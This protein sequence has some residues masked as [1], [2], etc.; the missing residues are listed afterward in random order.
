MKGLR[1]WHLILLIVLAVGIVGAGIGFLIFGAPKSSEPVP[2]TAFI[3]RV[4][5]GDT[6]VLDTGEYLR[7]IGIDTPEKDDYYF[8][9]AT[10]KN[11]ELVLGKTVRL[12][13]DVSETDRYNR[14]LRYV[15]VGDLFV[16]A[17]LVRLGYAKAWD[18]PPDSKHAQE[19]DQLQN[20]ALTSK[21]GMHNQIALDAWSESTSF[22]VPTPRT[23]TPSYTPYT[24]RNPSIYDLP[25]ATSGGFKLK[26][27]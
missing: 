23:Q 19:L 3:T 22:T 13:K 10:A 7:Y 27:Y 15:Y 18:Y 5:D 6:I 20:Y 12:E 9:E 25:P 26:R 21:L 8:A 14:L 17:E 24:P 1:T 16:N 2:V 11:A 4:I